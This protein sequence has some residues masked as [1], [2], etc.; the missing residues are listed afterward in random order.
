[1]KIN[2]MMWPADRTVQ[3]RYRYILLCVL[4][5]PFYNSLHVYFLKWKDIDRLPK[6]ISEVFRVMLNIKQRDANMILQK[7]VISCGLVHCF[8]YFR[9]GVCSAIMTC[10]GTTE[11]SGVGV[12]ATVSEFLKVTF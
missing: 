4:M 8:R 3:G 5:T 10:T 1:M 11:F 9:C 2:R 6:H 7:V 12:A